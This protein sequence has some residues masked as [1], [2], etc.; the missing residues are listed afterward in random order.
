MSDPS[1]PRNTDHTLSSSGESSG[2]VIDR[3]ELVGLL[4]EGGMGTVWLARQ[5]VPVQREVALKVIKLGMDTRAVVARFDAERQALAL[6]DHPHI[7]KVLDG[8]ATKSGRPYFVME[9]VDGTPI[10][11]YCDAHQLSLKQ[12]LE[13]FT[14]VCG[15]IQHAHLKGIIHRDIK[16][17]NVLVAM[18]D[19][20]PAP[21]V[22][23]FG[24]SKATSVELTQET[25]GTL[26]GG[27]VGTPEYMAPEQA[28]LGASDIDTRADVYSLGALLYE[29][30]TGTTPFDLQTALESGI[31][32][33]LLTIRAVDPAKPSTRI[34]TLGA[35]SLTIAS[36]RQA[37]VEVLRDDL[38]GDLDWIVMKALD[39]E[40]ERRYDSAREL[41]ADVQRYLQHEPVEAA[42]PSTR[43][44]VA[45]FVRRRRKTVLAA[46][47]IMFLLVAGS[48]GTG[49]GWWKMVR[50]NRA[51][52]VALEEKGL[53]L[54]EEGRQRDLAE[55]S[56]ARAR[57]AREDALAEA[58]RAQL[59]EERA[60]QRALELE[61]VTEFQSTQL[62]SI[63]VPLMGERLH[64]ALLAAV[65]Q[66]DSAALSAA[67]SRVN[68]T[69]IA[70]DSLRRNLF[71]TSIEAIDSQFADQPIVRARLLHTVGVVL[72]NM[73]RREAAVDPLVRALGLRRESL[74]NDDTETLFS[75]SN[76]AFLF[77]KLRRSD[78]AEVFFLEALDGFRR[79]HGPEH[80]DT[81]TVMNNYALHM[82]S[83]RRFEEAEA[84]LNQ[85]LEIARRALGLDHSITSSIE[86]NL[87]AH[88][89]TQGR[90][91][92][93]EPYLV[94]SLERNRRLLG[95][96]HLKTLDAMHQLASL[97]ETQHR[98]DLAVPLARECLERRRRVLGNDHVRTVASIQNM[99]LLHRSMGQLDQ[100]QEHFEEAL[101]TVRR[102]LPPGHRH[103]L[104]CAAQLG[105]LQ[106][107]LG[108]V[109]LAEPLLWE[110]LVGHQR[111][112]G[113]EAS[114]TRGSLRRFS[115]LQIERLKTARA[116]GDDEL[117]GLQLARVGA[118]HL[119]AGEFS[120][121]EEVL[122]QALDLLYATLAEDDVRRFQVESDLGAAL[123]AQG[124]YDEAEP[125][126]IGS[127]EML[128]EA[129]PASIPTEFERVSASRAVERVAELFEAWQ[130]ASP[131]AGHAQRARE[132][133]EQLEAW[134][135]ER[136]PDDD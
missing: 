56:A 8:G 61:Q 86:L 84:M 7:A 89:R 30:L 78:E 90:L 12:R 79:I 10:T 123:A 108:Q 52:D 35:A 134:R 112:L 116:A 136:A 111:I 131:T 120:K 26:A 74:G 29:L 129:D 14:Q 118:V 34:S 11:D 3:Y 46:S 95:E 28:T 62:S 47:L 6:M 113:P 80:A 40:R 104:N 91:A 92:D 44:R 94:S 102:T 75:I 5:S 73:S 122:V 51:L 98:F 54:D 66:E 106:F 100:A 109:D 124:R 1:P 126:L 85:A 99:G 115:E 4:G 18:H 23:D 133:R 65:S 121:A 71:E 110:S 114:L 64:A 119:F 21:K 17:S 49:I 25:L 93:A 63:D 135:A 15:A 130:E 87:G 132:W 41:A 67:F 16:P 32:E 36:R 24:V 97:Y 128:I 19:G 117:V 2:D 68:F 42:P 33:M 69:D 48:T 37:S 81:L 13:L 59:A 31:A 70:F 96:D 39:K 101:A 58:E 53:A 107:D 105:G 43:Y 38:R 50:A 20:D 88:L 77:Y 83:E 22:I 103:I 27:I 55:E 76:L 127:A 60:T 82:Q 45:K 125:L 57:V 72:Q 9:R